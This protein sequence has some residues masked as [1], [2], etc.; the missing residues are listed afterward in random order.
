MVPLRTVSLSES[1]SES[2]SESDDPL[3]LLLLLLLSPE[4][5]ILSSSLPEVASKKMCRASSLSSFEGRA[6]SASV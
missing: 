2:E 4:S 3:S 5:D 1:E 6:V